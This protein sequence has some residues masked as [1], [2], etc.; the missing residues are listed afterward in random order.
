M[1]SQDSLSFPRPPSDPR[2]DEERNRRTVAEFLRLEA[3][4]GLLLLIAAA[5]ALV[6][7]NSP[8][9]DTYADVRDHHL[10][11]PALGLDLSVGHWA[12]DGLLAVFFFVAGIELKR[13]LV[14]GELRRPATAVLP[15]VAAIGGMAVPALISVAVN[16]VGGGDQG[17]WA[18]PM[19]TDIAFALGVL[20][21][22]G[23]RLPSA[24]RVFL[25][26]L[27]VVDDLIAIIVI[28]IFF[29]SGLDLWALAGAVA[30]LVLFHLLHH[31]GVRGWHGAWYVYVP[32]ALAIWVLMANSGIHAT[33]AGVAMGMLLRSVPGPLEKQSPA[34][35]VG[36]LVH[37][38][39]AGIAVPLFA[40]FAAG[41]PVS[42]DTLSSLVSEP[43]PLGAALG[44]LLG[45]T[46][47][48]FGTTYLVARFTRARLSPTLRWPDVFGGALLAGIGFTVSL[49]ITELSFADT[50]ALEEQVKAA[51]L[52]GSLCAALIA[53]AVLLARGRRQPRAADDGGGGGEGGAPAGQ[54]T[55][56]PSR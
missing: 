37:P 42:G 25:L 26:T 3:S 55:S 44:L 33:I 4:G 47:G 49:L 16:G 28:A 56:A 8:L 53:S 21:V 41:V 13:E 38:Y 27:A 32:L 22:V 19:A 40:L 10:A 12:S 43:E 14:A 34:E 54:G 2:A 23:R 15:V 36:H 52:A 35:R 7:A 39:S 18:V 48:V 9:D 50:P 46:I 51:V 6:L 1:A 30:G 20:A 5:V 29:T 17:G 31:R 45:K 24:L 11:I